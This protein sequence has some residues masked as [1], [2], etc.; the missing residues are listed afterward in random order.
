[1]VF[2]RLEIQ[3]RYYCNVRQNRPEQYQKV[4][5]RNEAYRQKH[6]DDINRKRRDKYANDTAFRT[7]MSLQGKLH[8]QMHKEEI[9]LRRRRRIFQVLG[10][11]RCANCG[12]DD[13]R[14]LE[15]NHI[16]GGGN[17]E[18]KRRHHNMVM[19]DLLLGRRPSSDFNILCRLCNALDYLIRKY[20][21]VSFSVHWEVNTHIPKHEEPGQVKLPA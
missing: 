13:E 10:G 7:H 2:S 8:F 21:P 11:A 6:K 12:C 3:R 20:G 14:L 4:L 17:Q 16:A 18:Y 15:V 9:R 5:K 19:N 1:M